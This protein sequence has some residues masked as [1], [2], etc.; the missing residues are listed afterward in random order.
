[1]TSEY[2][3]AIDDVMDLLEEKA[4]KYRKEEYT[5]RNMFDEVEAHH[6]FNAVMY[7]MSDIKRLKNE[8]N[9]SN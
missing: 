7:I 5:S 6:K 1:M 8:H 4:I 2:N 3:K 9:N